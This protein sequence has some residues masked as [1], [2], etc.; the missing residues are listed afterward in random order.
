[1][2]NKS[3]NALSFALPILIQNVDVSDVEQVVQLFNL[4]LS[5][6]GEESL[7][8]SQTI[9]FT[10]L[11]K[12]EVLAATIAGEIIAPHIE[13]ERL[14]IRKLYIAITYHI[15][16]TGS[17]M[18]L[19]CDRNVG[20]ASEV[21]HKIAAYSKDAPFSNETKIVLLR[22]SLGVLLEMCKAWQDGDAPLV[23]QLNTT[24]LLNDVIPFLLQAPLDGA[25]NVKDAQTQAVLA[26]FGS[27]LWTLRDR[28]HA[29]R[30]SAYLF[31]VIQ[32][33]GWM[34]KGADALTSL[35]TSNLPITAYRDE[36]KK[37]IR[38][39]VP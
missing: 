3:L 39:N 33:S 11:D 10:L 36:F 29:E 17:K 15:F 28:M 7:A 30:F 24:V 22:S 37:F 38:A 19:F 21:Y 16:S 5:E 4:M 9:V 1:M 34:N 12:L 23:Q 14:G 18:A 26:D 8:V 27:L 2:G 13:V 20:R 35:L 25:L 31:N 32:R 6:L